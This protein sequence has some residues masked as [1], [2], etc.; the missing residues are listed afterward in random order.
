[1]AA[2]GNAQHWGAWHASTLAP[3]VLGAATY[4]LVVVRPV[5]AGWRTDVL[6]YLLVATCR[7]LR[8]FADGGDVDALR[9]FADRGV[10]ALC[11][12]VAK[13]ACKRSGAR[14]KAGRALLCAGNDRRNA[15]S[16][17]DFKPL[18]LGQIEVIPADFWTDRFLSAGSCLTEKGIRRNRAN[19]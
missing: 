17:K 4:M 16:G 13:N 14:T 19:T 6:V 5:T 1:M 12:D 10:L 8:R 9:A 3:A 2:G 15:P 18:Y 11:V 7:L